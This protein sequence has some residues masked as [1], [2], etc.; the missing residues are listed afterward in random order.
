MTSTWRLEESRPARVR[1]L[2]RGTVRSA[3]RFATQER[4][5]L[6]GARVRPL[7]GC[8]E[9][10]WSPRR[11]ERDG[12]RKKRWC[13]RAAKRAFGPQARAIRPTRRRTALVCAPELRRGSLR[14][15]SCCALGP[16]ATATHAPS[17][18]C[19]RIVLV[20]TKEVDA[21]AP[22]EMGPFVIRSCRR[23]V[24]GDRRRAV[25]RTDELARRFFTGATRS[26]SKRS[27][28]GS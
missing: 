13:G 28:V 12:D 27:V 7:A 19:E 15:A 1:R 18:S 24:D 5:A 14:T 4:R 8:L 21:S 10:S 9:P 2:A 16:R 17:R 26:R 23:V 6:R 20:P 22:S 11:R 25:S 3:S